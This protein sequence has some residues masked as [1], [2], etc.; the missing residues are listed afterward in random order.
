M[1][2]VLLIHMYEALDDALDTI[3]CETDDDPRAKA[4]P[5]RPLPHARPMR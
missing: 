2:L 4:E 3:G 1:L 5:S